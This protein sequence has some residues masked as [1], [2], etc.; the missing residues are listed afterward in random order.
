MRKEKK[1][2]RRQEISASLPPSGPVLQTMARGVAAMLGIQGRELL[3]QR[4]EVVERRKRRRRRA[5]AVRRRV[6]KMGVWSLFQ[7]MTF[8]WASCKA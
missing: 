3:L 6:M 7:K 1:R 5:A 4:S 8:P 2:R